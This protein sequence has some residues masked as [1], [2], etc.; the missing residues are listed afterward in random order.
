M[1]IA[2]IILGTIG[3]IISLLPLIATG[4]VFI[5]WL[6]WLF[7]ILGLIFGGIAMA[8][9]KLKP[10]LVGTIISIL[11]IAMYFVAAH[12]AATR[13]LNAV[14]DALGKDLKDLPGLQEALEKPE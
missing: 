4:M 7:A 1:A 12:V 6:S 14:S 8:K 3:F 11:T 2:A 9:G 10:G 13:A 5:S